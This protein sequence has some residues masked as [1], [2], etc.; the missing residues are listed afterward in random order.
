M[1]ALIYKDLLSVRLTLVVM[2]VVAV[3][4]AFW[5]CEGS[6]MSFFL[7]PAI[8]STV[9]GTSLN[10]DEKS[11]WMKF[12]VSSGV[13]RE[14]IVLNK[15]LLAVIVTLIGIAAGVIA[16]TAHNMLEP[17]TLELIE[18]LEAIVFGLAFG[19]FASTVMIVTAYRFG[20]GNA[21]IVAAAV[22]GGTVGL[23]VGVADVLNDAMWVLP[24]CA[25]ILFCI[26]AAIIPVAVK[27]VKDKDL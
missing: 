2:L 23:S 8:A 4:L 12:A 11:Q 3:L 24:V 6:V 21:G 20:A 16:I 10:L 22:I 9:V 27:V 25:L 18:T 26:S 17:V 14:H 15:V 7:A 13:S 19:M 1:N 5:I